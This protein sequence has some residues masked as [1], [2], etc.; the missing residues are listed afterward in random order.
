MRELFQWISVISDFIR[1]VNSVDLAN[2]LDHLESLSA[3]A[4]A[5]SLMTNGTNHTPDF[6][7]GL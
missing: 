3:V 1:V 5:S 2:G 6:S 7:T 4:A